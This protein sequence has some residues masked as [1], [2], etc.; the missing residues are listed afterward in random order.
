VPTQKEYERDAIKL[1]KHY[2]FFDLLKDTDS[3]G[4]IMT[5]LMLA[6]HSFDGRG[7]REGWRALT[8][9]RRMMHINKKLCKHKHVDLPENIE[10]NETEAIMVRDIL[11][12]MMPRR[13]RVLYL[14]FFGNYTFSQIASDLNIS[15]E[16]ARQC[17][18]KALEDFKCLYQQ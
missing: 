18:I 1:I 16:R 2:H 13:E 8:A 3:I 11:S 14:R 5:S 9:K 12:Q 4:D 6:D 17:C 10:T 7:T 15:I